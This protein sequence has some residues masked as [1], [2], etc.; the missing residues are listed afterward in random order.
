MPERDD[1]DRMK[2][3]YEDRVRA[4]TDTVTRR[5]R[6]LAILA[7]F[8][9]RVHGENEV[10][11]ILDIALDEILTRMDLR[12]AWIFIGTDEERKLRLIASRGVSQRYMEEIRTEG[13]GDCLC[14]EVFWTGHSMQARN[15]TQCP[16]M[17]DIVEGLSAPVA[18]ACIP[19]RFDQGLRGVL[20]VAAR[21]GQLFTDDELR[22][23]ETLGHQIGLAVERARHLEGERARIAVLFGMEHGSCIFRLKLG[24][25]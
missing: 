22:F 24:R 1:R 15:T 11:A 2:T 19:L 14:P 12:T 4:L 13:L 17:P 18:H 3:S 6:E 25:R 21:P 16:R 23:L 5:E 9:S 10:Q 7:A 20:N 8:A